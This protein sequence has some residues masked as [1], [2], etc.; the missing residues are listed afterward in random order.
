MIKLLEVQKEIGTIKKDSTNPFF[1]A[2]YFD[3]NSLLEALKPVLN[4]HGLVVIQ[5][6]SNIDGKTSLKTIVID[7]EN[8]KV[9]S[10]SET[11]LFHCYD[12]KDEYK[13]PSSN[14]LYVLPIHF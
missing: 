10:E 14:L 2:K 5:P 1:K 12:Q 4:A 9:V 13:N 3:I 7:S 6:L 8:D 11:I